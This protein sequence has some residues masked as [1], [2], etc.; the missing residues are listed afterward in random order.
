MDASISLTPVL[1]TGVQSS[2]VVVMEESFR[3]ADARL[4]GGKSLF[5]PRTWAGL[6]SCDRHRNED[7]LEVTSTSNNERCEPNARP[8]NNRLQRRNPIVAGAFGKAVPTQATAYS[9][10]TRLRPARLERYS[11]SSARLRISLDSRSGRPNSLTPP[12]MVD[13]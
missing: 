3:H 5:S 7:H 8:T 2:P 13:S 10:D 11:P 12:L 6:D 1:V 9:A 4:R